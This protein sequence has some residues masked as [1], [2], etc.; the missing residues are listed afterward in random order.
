MA[1]E[2]AAVVLVVAVTGP[3][4]GM[5]VATVAAMVKWAWDMV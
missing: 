4:G 5:V 3:E 2:G 1:P